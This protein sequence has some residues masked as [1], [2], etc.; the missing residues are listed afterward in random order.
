MKIFTNIK[1]FF[2]EVQ[3]LVISPVFILITILGNGLIGVFGLTFYLL[4]KDLNPK[5]GGL[6]DGLWWSFAT[7]TTTGYGDITPVTFTGKVL[8]IVLM[9]IGT[10][11]F[12]VYTGLFAEAILTSEKV[13]KNH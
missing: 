7:A 13:R 2:H 5:L 8:G 10:A 4:E 3:K 11:I 6:I 1:F 9:L 12:A